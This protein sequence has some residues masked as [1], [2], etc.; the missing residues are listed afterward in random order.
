M[1]IEVI[2]IQNLR[3]LTELVTELW[4]DCSFEEEFENFRSI[5]DSKKETCYI[6][7]QQE[8]CIAF[9]HVNIRNDYVEGTTDLPVAYIEALYIKPTF[10]KQGIAGIL[11]SVAENW[12]KEKGLKQLA[13]DTDAENQV[14]INFHKKAGFT[15]V[16]RVV[17]FI[18]NL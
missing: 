16:G 14:S 8:Q 11:I 1:I 4:D 2:S 10:Q 17:C 15:E 3:Q 7:K 18:K 9:I 13:S 12:A 5:I 6:A